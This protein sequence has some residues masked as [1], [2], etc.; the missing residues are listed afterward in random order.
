M[1]MAKRPGCGGDGLDI[2]LP[3]A[4][5]NPIPKGI[6]WKGGQAK[7]LG[8]TGM[9]NRAECSSSDPSPGTELC[10]GAES[11][12]SGERAKEPR[13]RE[14]SGDGG[15]AKGCLQLDPPALLSYW[16][17]ACPGPQLHFLR[18]ES[19]RR[20]RVRKLEDQN[21]GSFRPQLGSSHPDP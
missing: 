2:S 7:C 16:Y 15:V 3:M 6:W 14:K 18:L 5:C 19:L 21:E 1:L 12:S 17:L 13:R 8:V 4:A 9:R 20:L 10:L 11:E